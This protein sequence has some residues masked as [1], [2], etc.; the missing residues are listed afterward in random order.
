[1]TDEGVLLAIDTCTHRGVV[2]VGRDGALLADAG[3]VTRKGATGS[4][5]GLVDE[6]VRNL[7]LGPSSI[8][9]L[10][11]G[12][13]PGT[14]T[15][16]KV[17]VSTAKALSLALGAPLL[18]LSTLEILAAGARSEG[19]DV[20]ATVA[21][22]GGRY[23][24]AFF[25]PGEPPPPVPGY[26]RVDAGSLAAL[27]AERG[28]RLLL[29][30]EADGELTGALERAGAQFRV[31]CLELDPRAFLELASGRMAEADTRG[32]VNVQ[33]IYLRSPV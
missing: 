23:F 9:R 12:V 26:L 19:T 3:F 30:G 21:G 2:A 32:A 33:P 20:L 13:G 10:A 15:G 31:A 7:G 22:G 1:M 4:L 17:G 5:M 6:T 27:A 14:F 8:G 18:G 25:S 16:V 24:A 29:A 28:A 11:V